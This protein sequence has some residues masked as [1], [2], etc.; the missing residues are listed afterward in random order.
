MIL[1]YAT[2]LFFLFLGFIRGSVVALEEYLVTFCVLIYLQIPN[3]IL[4]SLFFV[5]P[6]QLHSF[7]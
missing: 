5:L 6:D 3:G 4:C 2:F 7:C 1:C